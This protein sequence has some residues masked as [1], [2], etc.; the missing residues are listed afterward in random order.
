MPQNKVPT[1]LAIL[2]GN[3]GKRPLP[4]NEPKPQLVKPSAPA[5]L[6]PAAKKHWRKTVKELYAAKLM[7]RLDIDA[8]TLFCQSYATWIE[9]N[10]RL[11]A[12]GMIITPVLGTDDDGNPLLG[13]PTVSPWLGISN[14]CFD[15]M[16]R[17]LVEFG[18]TPAS[19]AKVTTVSAKEKKPDGWGKV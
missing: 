3:P 7:T 17:I 8:L 12:D 2:K 4:K 13:V 16:R 15:Q 11:M 19:R 14:K 18:M 10:E 6:C 1:N 5:H 9:A